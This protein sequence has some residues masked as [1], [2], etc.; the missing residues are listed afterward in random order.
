MR[1]ASCRSYQPGAVNGVGDTVMETLVATLVAAAA[2]AV[3]AAIV[4]HGVLRPLLEARGIIPWTIRDSIGALPLVLF[5]SAAFGAGVERLSGWLFGACGVII[6][7]AGAF[8][9]LLFIVIGL[10][11]LR[12][13]LLALRKLT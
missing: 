12:L 5:G 10:L 6:P 2:S 3:V 7:P 8:V 4:G 13:G 9:A 11:M 1:E